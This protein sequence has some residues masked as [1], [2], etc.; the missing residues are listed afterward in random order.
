ML[1][2]LRSKRARALPFLSIVLFS[3]G[4]VSCSDPDENAVSS[5]SATP[6]SVT[7]FPG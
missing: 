5:V 7:I 4:L 6:G 2:Y 3:L 1:G